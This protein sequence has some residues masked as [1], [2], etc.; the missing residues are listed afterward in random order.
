MKYVFAL[1]LLVVIA[2]VQ[3]QREIDVAPP[4]GSQGALSQEADKSST[5]IP[6][7]KNKSSK[8]ENEDDYQPIKKGIEETPVNI[9]DAQDFPNN[10]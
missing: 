5:D 7:E 3:A 2:E 1:L 8:S 4:N 9:R 6:Y 10:I